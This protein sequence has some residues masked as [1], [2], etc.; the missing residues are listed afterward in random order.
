MTI[1][2]KIIII[3]DNLLNNKLCEHLLN[4]YFKTPLEIVSFISPE[5][6]IRH[7]LT[8]P[9]E[10][11]TLL[12]LDIN[13]PTLTGWEVIDELD[14]FLHKAKDYFSVV[15]LSSSVDPRDQQK[16][17]EYP[18]IRAVLEKPLRREHLNSLFVSPDS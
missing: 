5:E 12:L 17:T 8:D 3:D 13:M 10:K 15:I 9:T 4:Q 7:I 14:V 2:N 6:G 1:P 11:P 18:H 16:A